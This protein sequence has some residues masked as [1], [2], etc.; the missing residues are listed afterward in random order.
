MRVGV[1]RT[2]SFGG[3]TAERAARVSITARDAAGFART[4]ALR[5]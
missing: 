4:R 3:S 1:P 5:L 2:L